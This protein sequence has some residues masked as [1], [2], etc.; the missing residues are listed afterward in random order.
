MKIKTELLYRRAILKYHKLFSEIVFGPLSLNV[1]GFRGY[2]YIMTCFRHLSPGNTTLIRSH[3]IARGRRDP[4]E[5]VE[6]VSET[7]NELREA[8]YLADQILSKYHHSLTTR[9]IG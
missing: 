9:A 3:E 4:I 6:Q 7:G 1:P 2:I 8:L 5:V